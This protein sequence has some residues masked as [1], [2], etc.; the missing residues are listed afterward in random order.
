MRVYV[1]DLNM[2]KAQTQP[3][4]II[5]FVCMMRVTPLQKNFVVDYKGRKY[6]FCSAFCRDVFKIKP[7][8]FLKS[9]SLNSNKENH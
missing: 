5:D 4:E 1:G 3:H 7:E 9:K 6:Y 8:L 2:N